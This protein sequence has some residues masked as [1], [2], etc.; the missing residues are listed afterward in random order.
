MYAMPE[1]SALQ[2]LIGREVGQIA[3][4]PHSVQFRLEG[5]GFI[6]SDF[7]IEHVDEDGAVWRYDCVAHTGPPLLLRRLLRKAVSG[8]QTEGHCLTLTFEGGAE[9]RLF[10]EIGPYE[11]GVIQLTDDQSNYIVY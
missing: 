2:S 7:D 6:R 4:D 5:G 9:L 10:S 11:C 8:L 1:A 3:L